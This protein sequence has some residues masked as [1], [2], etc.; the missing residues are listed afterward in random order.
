[1]RYGIFLQCVEWRLMSKEPIE[2]IGKT[3]ADRLIKKR[4]AKSREATMAPVDAWA[5]GCSRLKPVARVGI[6][7]T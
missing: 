2:G 1:M 4:F 3:L 7:S 5:E 6:E